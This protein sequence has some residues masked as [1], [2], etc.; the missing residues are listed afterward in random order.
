MRI[1]NI[2]TSFPLQSRVTRFPSGERNYHIFYQLLLGA[3]PQLLSKLSFAPD[4]EGGE[5][6][7]SPTANPVWEDH[8]GPSS[9]AIL[10]PPSLPVGK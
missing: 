3:D 9:K 5:K 6:C 2:S 7:P 10:T 1:T 4:C 8:K